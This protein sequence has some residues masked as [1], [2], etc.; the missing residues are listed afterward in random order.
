MRTHSKALTGGIIG[1]F[2][3]IAATIFS[4]FKPGMLDFLFYPTKFPIMFG[5]NIAEDSLIA[6]GL[7]IIS[8][9]ITYFLLGAIIA[10][11]VGRNKGIPGVPKLRLKK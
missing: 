9:V 8:I 4:Q 2:F 1:V 3:I 11:L 7:G 5:L 6:K 10:L